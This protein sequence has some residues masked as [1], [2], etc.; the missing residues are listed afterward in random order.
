MLY[1]GLASVVMHKMSS[2][3]FGDTYAVARMPVNF[4][5]SL[6][7]NTDIQIDIYWFCG[8]FS[9]LLATLARL[10]QSV[11]ALAGIDH[12]GNNGWC[13]HVND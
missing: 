12:K 6:A 1:N 8:G 4:D 10:V 9:G 2:N 5:Y 3:D 11:Q 13:L 7:A